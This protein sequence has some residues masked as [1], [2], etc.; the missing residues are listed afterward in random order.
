MSDNALL[1][2]IRAD[3]TTAMK[4]RDAVTVRTLRAVIA[5]VQ[6]AEVA[7]DTATKLT[8]AEV[9]KLLATQAKRRVEAAEAFDQGNRP[10]K[11]ADE[12]AELAILESYLP[13]PLSDDELVAVIEQTLAD[14]GISEM[15]DM[16]RAMKAV[17]AKV[18]GM[19]R[20]PADGKRV[21]ALVRERLS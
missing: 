4:S 15:S 5:A 16:G 14:E 18:A 3:L 12:R 20:G 7:G 2:R 9:E 10:E 21:A 6:E 13:K 1:A 11:A 19:A 17:N 8:E